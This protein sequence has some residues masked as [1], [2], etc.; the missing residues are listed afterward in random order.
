LRAK[1]PLVWKV[2]ILKRASRGKFVGVADATTA[3]QGATN[4]P[5]IKVFTSEP[6][7]T[8]SSAIARDVSMLS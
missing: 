6:V 8:T 7:Q 2:T 3:L 5:V 4:V 1:C